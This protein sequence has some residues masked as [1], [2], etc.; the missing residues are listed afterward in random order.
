[1]ERF[2]NGPFWI[3][4][5]IVLGILAL[6]Q[7]GSHWYY[8]CEADKNPDKKVNFYRYIQPPTKLAIVNHM[9]YGTLEMKYESESEFDT[10]YSLATTRV[11]VT[12]YDVVRNIRE[13]GDV[14]LKWTAHTSKVNDSIIIDQNYYHNKTEYICDI[15]KRWMK[16]N[17]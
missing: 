4:V 1:M 7:G 12:D 17:I 3:I 2:F 6:N 8:F 10:T 13:Y 15:E 16:K 14:E 5:L 9:D 11:G